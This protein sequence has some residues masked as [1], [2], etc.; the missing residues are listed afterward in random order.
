VASSPSFYLI[1][2]SGQLI[3]RPQSVK[4]IDAWVDWKLGKGTSN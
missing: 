3:L 2:Q 1:D 4:Q